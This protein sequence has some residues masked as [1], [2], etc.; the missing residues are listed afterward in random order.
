MGSYVTFPS[1]ITCAL[2]HA[3][4]QRKGLRR[5]VSGWLL[6]RYVGRGVICITL[7]VCD[8]PGSVISLSYADPSSWQFFENSAVLAL[9]RSRLV[10]PKH[11]MLIQGCEKYMARPV[12]HAPGR[13]GSHAL[14]AQLKTL[15]SPVQNKVGIGRHR[16]HSC[17]SLKR[18]SFGLQGWERPL[19]SPR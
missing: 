10:S 13:K 12:H 2:T 5:R 17:H 14:D 11:G 6:N 15:F 19:G 9:Y 1:Q 3:L 18:Q 4:T 8:I 7:S 16:R